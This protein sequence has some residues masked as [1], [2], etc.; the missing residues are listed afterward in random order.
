MAIECPSCRRLHR[1]EQLTGDAARCEMCGSL[2]PLPPPPC[3][4]IPT[5]AV[6][7]GGTDPSGPAYD[8]PGQPPP[9]FRTADVG[10]SSFF[11]RNG[12]YVLFGMVGWAS[13]M[14]IGVW[15]K[16][17]PSSRD[18]NRVLN[19]LPE[20][21]RVAIRGLNRDGRLVFAAGRPETQDEALAVLSRRDPQWANLPSTA[22]ACKLL[23]PDLE[24]GT[25]KQK[26]AI[27]K[28]VNRIGSRASEPTGAMW[29]IADQDS[30]VRAAARATIVALGPDLSGQSA[31]HAELLARLLPQI[32]AGEAG[33]AG[34]LEDKELARTVRFLRQ[35]ATNGTSAVPLLES[36]ES[37]THRRSSREVSRAARVSLDAIDP[38]WVS[39]ADQPKLL[40]RVLVDL[41]DDPESMKVAGSLLPRLKVRSEQGELEPL[42]LALAV[43][44]AKAREVVLAALDAL[45][46]EWRKSQ[47]IQ[48]LRVRLASLLY[49]PPTEITQPPSDMYDH[50]VEIFIASGKGAVSAVRFE[51][52]WAAEKEQR[53]KNSKA[54][55]TGIQ[56]AYEQVEKMMFLRKWSTPLLDWKSALVPD[57]TPPRQMSADE[58]VAYNKAFREHV[59]D[60]IKRLKPP[61]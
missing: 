19:Q 61:E 36:L 51:A 10:R 24:R 57:K 29:A 12:R 45:K 5:S 30:Q 17:L 4:A 14:L 37:G 3:S 16:G 33:T 47:S 43:K 59:N 11:R 21:D 56:D 49:S 48:Q 6:P 38:S 22:S 20:S 40:R 26:L 46:P 31:S 58:V 60:F 55:R 34:N 8:R 27:L 23:A 50:L 32:E 18:A 39:R 7:S 44:P 35:F 54:P 1:A 9:E 28:L 15:L 42:F 41:E 53:R 2:I 13:L 52:A 25:T